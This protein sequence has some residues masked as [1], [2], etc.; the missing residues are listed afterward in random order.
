M[1]TTKTIALTIRNFVSKVMSLLFNTLY[2]FVIV[3]LP[4]RNVNNLR[5]AD[6]TIVMTESEEALNSFLVKVKVEKLA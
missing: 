5:Y 6:D 2:M 4:R 1:T 3:F